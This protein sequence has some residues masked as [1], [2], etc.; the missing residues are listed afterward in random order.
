VPPVGA[1][2]WV[3][4]EAGDV[5]RPIW[6]G[7][8]WGLSDA[9]DVDPGEIEIRGTD[10]TLAVTAEGVVVSRWSPKTAP[11]PPKRRPG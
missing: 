2:V 3:E 11:L 7:S 10:A 9:P 6:S 5:E 4:F 1:G 8:W